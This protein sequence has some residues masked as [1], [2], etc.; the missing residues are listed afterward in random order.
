MANKT[1]GQWVGT[2][3]GAV[4]GA[5]LG[6]PVD[7]AWV[8][9]AM[10]GASVGGA[11][12]AA[13][14]PPRG[15]HLVGPR[16]SDLSQQTA[17][18]GAVIPRL[19]GN[20]AVTGNVFWVEN[21]QLK[22]VSRT[23]GGGKGGGGGS[24]STTYSYYATFAIGL[25]EGPIVGVQRIW[26]G[27]KLVYD[28]GSNDHSAIMASN[29]AAKLFTLHL[30]DENQLPDDRMQA[31]LGAANTPAY[32]GL[33][34]LVFK[35]L[36]LK[37]YGNTL[38]GAPVKVEV[39][40]TGAVSSYIPTSRT[41]PNTI[42]HYKVKSNGRMFVS[43]GFNS[44]EMYSSPDGVTWAVNP[45]AYAGVV[46]SLAWGA[47]RWVAGGSS[48][49]LVSKDGRTWADATMSHNAT[50]TDI[51]WD[52]QRFI[53]VA[54]TQ[55]W[56]VS[57][58]GELWSALVPPSLDSWNQIVNTG[59]A[60]VAIKNTG[61]TYCYSSDGMSWV[62]KT[63]PLNTNSAKIYTDGNKFVVFDGSSQLMESS[64][65][66]NWTVRSSPTFLV[67]QWDGDNWVG[68]NNSTTARRS[69]DL[70]TWTTFTVPA[71]TWAGM[72]WDGAIICA[73][74]NGT[75]CMTIKKT[76]IAGATTPLSTII[77]DELLRTNLL[78]AADY[79]VTALTSQVRGY[80]I[81]TVGAIRSALETLQAAYPFDVIQ[82]GYKIKFVPRGGASVATIPASALDARAGGDKPGIAITNVREMD[83]VLPRRVAV[84]FLDIDREY[85]LSE[86]YDERLNTTAVN[87]M[88]MEMPLVMDADEG[89][90]AAQKLLY[91]YWLERYDVSFK[92]PPSYRA[93]EPADV[94]TLLPDSGA[95]NLRLTS[96]SYLPDG[97]LECQA[98]Y[99][100]ASV[101]SPTARGESGASTGNGVTLKGDTRCILLD[102]PALL[103]A[104]DKPGFPVAMGGYLSGWPGGILSRSDDAGQTWT[105]ILGEAAPGAMIGVAWAAIGAGRT[106]L[107]DKA[108]VL[109]AL[110]SG[111]PLYSITEAAMLNGA[112][113]FAYGVKGR[114]EIIAAQTCALQGDGSYKLSDLLR[115]RFGT[116]WACG[117][118]AIGDDLIL[119]DPIATPFVS[120]TL[121]S[122]GLSRL[123]QAT[124]TGVDPTS[125]D[126]SSF[127]YTGVNLECLSPV[128]LNGNRHPSTNDW[129]L[130][131]IR[132]TR[133]GGEWRDYVDATLGETAQSYEVEIYSSAA[134]TTLKRTITGLTTPAATYT[135]AQ[136]VTDFGSNQSTLYV[137]VYQ[138]SANVGR[139]YPLT[140]S[141]TR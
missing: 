139:G 79:D 92:L 53:A 5:Y 122:I 21:N 48:K 82:S 6:D 77:E 13:I 26:I 56:A 91:L 57:S 103:D 110:F 114:W 71:A 98:K 133:V 7:G 8:G 25:C 51:T 83:T 107:V 22:E 61:T 68:L 19:Y 132:R 32:R 96:T 30:G 101:Y 102:I 46:Y 50:W 126:E 76:G 135:S 95:L 75:N 129:S 15:P 20:I 43:T 97:R 73:V 42:A 35:D 31:T 84:K 86:Q 44:S 55:N 109:P 78:S 47:N 116:E 88:S 11:I 63:F 80:R 28:A 131:W 12:G 81:G 39:I 70:I 36:P 60:W 34:Y 93:L 23:Q 134:Y 29:Q 118:H 62:H 54:D 127:T 59:D 108:R 136:Q 69:A 72:E 106:D 16:L 104:A 100:S 1:A 121:N 14:D 90:Q 137:K 89:A 41:I 10:M 138:L 3:V 85:D 119:L 52:G 24:Q 37:D 113:H 4:V 38:L 33:A 105:A 120:T 45:I 128:Y 87:I 117:L 17:T 123:Y 74:G 125:N 66:L 99:N 67:V 65:G 18:Y 58:D 130:D 115:G 124:T 141:I 9:A 112:N 40:A 27:Q 94:I 2:V 64:D 49:M 140:T 111:G